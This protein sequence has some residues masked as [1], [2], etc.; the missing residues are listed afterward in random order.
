MMWCGHHEVK[1]KEVGSLKLLLEL[2]IFFSMT[3]NQKIVW[4][5]EIYCCYN[6]LPPHPMG[7]STKY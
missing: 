6:P 2:M 4:D 5:L 7:G 1:A 3:V